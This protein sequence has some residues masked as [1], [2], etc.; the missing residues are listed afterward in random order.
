[1]TEA[2]YTK[3][4]CHDTWGHRLLRGLYSSLV[5]GIG[6]LVGG[7][8]K[9]GYAMLGVVVAVLVAVV[10]I[11]L[12]AVE[13]VTLL[14]VWLISP[15]NLLGL[16]IA[17]VLLLLFRLYAVA[18][19]VWLRRTRWSTVEQS[20]SEA[21]HW[22]IAEPAAA[23]GVEPEIDLPGAGQPKWKLPL[24]MAGLAALL[25]FT[26]LPHVWVGYN[27]VY[28]FRDV[29]STVFAQE[30]TTTTLAPTTT[31]P[32]SGPT[33]STE[34]VNTTTTVAPVTVDAGDDGRLTVVFIGAD[35]DETRKGLARNDT[36]IVASFELSTGRIALFSLPR[37][38]G[39]LPLSEEAQ[40]A[41]GVKAY[42][43]LLNEMYGAAWRAW[44]SH[45]ELA[46]E[47]GDPGGEVMRD[48][49]SLVL[50]IQVDYYAVV[51][52]LG[53]VRMVDVLGGV[54][55]YFDKDLRMGISS[56]TSEGDY[57]YFNVKE[58][59]NHLDG[60]GA[61]A[62]ARTRKDSSDYTRMGRQ[63]C[64]IAA[65]MAQT[66]MTELVWN[67][68]AIM[69]VIK[70]MVSTDIP[71]GAIQELVKLRSKLM[72]D[73]MLSIG[74]I[75]PKYTRGTAGYPDPDRNGWVLNAKLIQE[76]VKKI[77]ENPEAVLAE[78]KDT[79]LDTGDCWKKPEEQ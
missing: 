64:L 53:L 71:I 67:F 3:Y 23:D 12:L 52:M 58:G 35:I 43:T 45:P 38:A 33:D 68:P 70:S 29:L 17:D 21:T 42:P 9:R 2:R 25:V 48:T 13:D 37:N 30:T 44:P 11:V 6:Q 54:D 55:I 32:G 74:F 62:F 73:E 72:T 31:L 76:T 41:F 16:L 78:S 8:R 36:T 49:A 39:K 40:E 20:T 51:D 27:Y 7:A 59:I 1:M 56:P 34:P 65:L 79:G 47:G 14:L 10:L 61:L 46:P 50:G 19:A 5:P 75:P 24:A 18:D 15:S 77:L 63:R 60:L 66:G 69:D 4:T 26:V 22:S 57:L 28:K